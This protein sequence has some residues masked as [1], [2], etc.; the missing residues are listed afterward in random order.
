ME[1]QNDVHT[2]HC[3]KKCGCKYGEDKPEE[4]FDDEPFIACSVV[5]GRKKQE[6]ACGK[7]STCDHFDEGSS[8]SAESKAMLLR[9]IESG[10]TE[11]AIYLGSFAKFNR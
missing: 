10:K 1:K 9:G 3:C 2:R 7:Q 6:N 4:S 8:I 11:S 5:S